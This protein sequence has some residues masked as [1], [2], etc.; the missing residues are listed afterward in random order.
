MT[1]DP[2]RRL[3]AFAAGLT[4]LVGALGGVVTAMVFP[5][6]A[7]ESLPEVR[8]GWAVTVL[9]FAALG[10][11]YV[12][13][14]VGTAAILTRENGHPSVY[15]AA[16][17]AAVL[18]P[19]V[20]PGALLWMVER[21]P[22]P[23]AWTPLVVFWV[24]PNGVVAVVVCIG[25]V[26]RRAIPAAAE[27]DWILVGNIAVVLVFFSGFLG[28]QVVAPG[29]ADEHATDT[30][31]DVELEFEERTTEDGRL[32]VIEHAGG[33]PA[34]VNRLDIRGEG[35]ADVEG[36]DQTGPGPWAGEA[37]GRAPRGGGPAVVEGDT[38]TVGIEV[39]PD[40]LLR[41]GDGTESRGAVEYYDCSEYE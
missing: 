9:L 21:A 20:A 26:F 14:P 25:A 28:V 4:L 10:L 17:L 30:R 15:G 40:C 37:T 33:E 29:F 8:I 36:A 23:A 6:D 39:T 1:R 19:V 24:V 5:H 13:V 41:I 7:G 3:V 32:V 18:V 11:L 31:P 12:A 16:A 34:P 38:V 22:R 27:P 2:Q 35:F